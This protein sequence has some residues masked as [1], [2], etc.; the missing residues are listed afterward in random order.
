MFFSFIK[1]TLK[2]QFEDFVQVEFGRL[3]EEVKQLQVKV[4]EQEILLSS[5]APLPPIEKSIDGTL[6]RGIVGSETRAAA[7]SGMPR[8]CN[9][10]R[11]ADPSLTSGVHW[12]DPDGQGVGDD[13]I[14]VYCDMSSGK[15]F[16]FRIDISL[17]RFLHSFIRGYVD[18][19]RH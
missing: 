18:W 12:I 13:P 4:H 6:N 1:E 2:A 3:K 14:Q 5:C 8:S 15:P 17:T 7:K 11:L 19:T 16:I 9:E 10:A